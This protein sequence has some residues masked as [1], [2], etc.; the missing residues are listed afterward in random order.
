MPSPSALRPVVL[1][2]NSRVWA[3][4]K[5]HLADGGA[6]W[7]ALGHAELDGFAFTP[8]DR[9]WVL[10]Y[11]R[12]PAENRALL[13]RLAAAGV[14]EIVYLS[15]SSTIVDGRTRCYEYPRVKA[16]AEAEALALPNGRALVVGLMHDRLDELPAGLNIATRH[17][18]LAAFM[19]RPDWGPDNARRRTL[20]EPVRRDWRS[21]AE[22]TAH[23]VYAG[24]MR[25]TGPWPCLLRPL[26]LLLRLAGWRWYGYT[27]L[28]N[29]LWMSKIS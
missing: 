1:G 13:Q 7:Q 26:D 16:L 18:D 22:R 20:F 14:A 25:L 21:P 28:A 23:A 27:H 8:A 9:V 2:R 6:H 11:S 15:S 29:R 5:P 12:D 4:V 17:A 19:A 10:S 24:L 3:A